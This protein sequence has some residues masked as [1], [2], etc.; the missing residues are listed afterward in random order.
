MPVVLEADEAGP[1]SRFASR[2]GNLFRE[3]AQKAA[4]EAAAAPA[5]QITPALISDDDMVD[6]KLRVMVNDTRVIETT[7]P[8]HRVSIGRDELAEVQPLGPTQLLV[9]AKQVGT[10]QV[11]FWDAQDR[12]QTLLLQSSAD[13]RVIADKL[14][15]L[16]PGANIGVSDLGGKIALV[17]TARDAEQAELAERIASGFGD[18]ENLLR[19][20]GGQ[21]VA[22]RIQ[23][24]EVSRSAGKQFGVNF[25]FQDNSGTIFGSNVG[26]V[27]PLAFG[28]DP[29]TGVIDRLGIL[30]PT[31]GVQLFGLGRLD[32]NPFAY[33]IQALRDSNL[34]RILAD[35]ELVVASGEQ[36]SFLAGGEFAVPVPQ[37]EGIAIE[38]REFGIKLDYTPVVLGNGQIRM[39]LLSEVSDIDATVG[40]RGPG[41]IIVPGLRKRVT[42]TTVELLDGQTLAIS[43]LIR[44][45]SVANKEGIP[46]LGDLPIIGALFRST[47][48]QRE[49][50]ELVVLVTPRLVAPLDATAMP[51][52]PG[53]TWRHPNDVE[54]FLGGQM[55]GDAGVALPDDADVDG[56]DDL[57]SGPALRTRYAFTEATPVE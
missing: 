19:I 4:V 51:P 33:Y 41:G 57:A 5:M 56:S 14:E 28:S 24:A 27:N 50:T 20:A 47:A 31:T 25:G 29:D 45:R 12:R 13:L 15:E 38:Y 26:Q 37:E 9:T 52:L 35:P 2:F 55:G 49:E 8:F 54:L 17:G 48:Y 43:G 22:L 34:L 3:V 39:R 6:G 36:G 7:R 42:S 11:V 46:L 30:D 32:G 18:V 1:L 21:Q 23:F 40:T 53:Q 44:S 16:L 10:T